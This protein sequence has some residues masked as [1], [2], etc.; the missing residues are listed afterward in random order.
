[1]VIEEAW[2]SYKASGCADTQS[3]NRVQVD[4]EAFHEAWRCYKATSKEKEELM[5]FLDPVIIE[6]LTILL[7]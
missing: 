3:T 6:I 5:D 4:K 1:M 7:I 2:T